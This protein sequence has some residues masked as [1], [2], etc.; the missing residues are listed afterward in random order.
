MSQP[1][2]KRAEGPDVVK[3]F[4]ITLVVFGH[5]LRGL[6]TAGIV[7]EGGVW[8]DVDRVLYMFHMPLF[9]F[10]SGLF[11]EGVFNR[12]GLFPYIKRI[13]GTMLVP[14]VVWSYLQTGLQY[15]ASGSA[16]HKLS[17]NDVLTS[18]FPPKH[19]FWFLW[20]LFC[21][22]VIAAGMLSLK[23]GSWWFGG[24]ALSMIGLAIVGDYVS[25]DLVTYRSIHVPY[26]NAALVNLPY[27]ALGMLLPAN[28]LSA[29][30]VNDIL[31]IAAFLG[32]AT[33]FYREAQ[34]TNLVYYICSIIC[35]LAFYKFG[36]NVSN[37][38]ETNKYPV[39]SAVRRSIVFIGMNSMIIYLAHVIF[40]AGF[41]VFLLKVSVN[42]V[43]VHLA[44]GTVVGLLFPLLLVPVGKALTARLPMAGLVLP[45]RVP[46]NEI[47]AKKAA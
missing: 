10:L 18:P 31:C 7:P 2:P 42:D 44:G 30:K 34:P 8:A 28:W 16:N 23:R 14:L 12:L 5:T 40:E 11:V 47:K 3:A 33:L 15:L 17:L 38:M 4:A 36:L 35:V 29:R 19:Q 9:F 37:H 13:A 32:A 24:F 39:L 26:L 21:M 46:H 6:V 41:R 22:S 1:Y 43:G 27:F 20:A 25:F 45:V